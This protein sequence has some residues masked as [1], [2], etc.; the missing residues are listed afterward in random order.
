MG[1]QARSG[2]QLK[3]AGNSFGVGAGSAGFAAR[4]RHAAR[5]WKMVGRPAYLP[6]S[7]PLGL[8]AG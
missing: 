1:G 7:V 4:H 6:A 2:R 8:S 3:I 5:T